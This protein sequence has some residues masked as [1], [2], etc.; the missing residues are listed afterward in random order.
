MSLLTFLQMRFNQPVR[1]ETTPRFS[2]VV[3][4]DCLRSPVGWVEER[5][6]A[7]RRLCDYIHAREWPVGRIVLR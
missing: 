4:I 3:S 5:N 7:T 6:P 2:G 1:I